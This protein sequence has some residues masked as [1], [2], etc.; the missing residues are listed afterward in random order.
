MGARISHHL[1]NKF[2]NNKL[3]DGLELNFW[4]SAGQSFGAF[5]TKGLKLILKETQMIMLLKDYQVRLF[6]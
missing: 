2:G 6:Q 3:E 4:G 1:Y 5:G